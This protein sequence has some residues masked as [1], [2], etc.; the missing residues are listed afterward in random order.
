[1]LRL[2]PALA[3][4]LGLAACDDAPDPLNI[5][6]K[7]FAESQILAEMMAALAEDAGIP[8]TRRLN[9]G[10]TE[11]LLEA[12]KRG[13]IDLYPEYNG[14]G[15]V[16]LGQ[17]A[18][19]D[20]DAA[21]EEVAALYEPLG[22]IWGER[23]GFDNTYGL[24]MRAGRA[25]ELGVDRIS[26]LAGQAGDLTIGVDENFRARP[27]DGL[28]PM[29]ARYG[30]DFGT[31][32]TVTPDERP[33]LYNSVLGGSADVIEV[34][35]TDGQIADL[36]LVLLEDDLD[37][38]PVYQ[39]APLVRS[40]AL[41]RH[42]GLRDVL[43]TLAGRLDPATMQRLN[44]Q[45]DLDSL[46]PR[47]VARAAL[48]EMGLI[49]GD[50]DLDVSE[51][52]VVA[53]SPLVATD[54]MTGR[55]LR[56]VREAYTGRR[57]VLEEAPDALDA[58]GGGAAPLAIASAVEFVDVTGGS[59]PVQRPYEAVGVVGQS[60]VHVVATGDARSLADVGMLATGPEGSASHRA[61]SVLATGFDG[62]TVA[63][64]D[65]G[66]L[67][68]GEADAVLV[69]APVGAP[70]VAALLEDGRLIPVTGWNAGSNL[71]RYP[72]LREARI[73]AGTYDGQR[74]AVD[75]LSSQLVLAGPVIADTDAVG[76]Q[77]PAA[78]QPTEV[79]ALSEKTVTAIDAAL[80]SPTGIDP[81][82]PRAAALTPTLPEPAAAVSPSP[83]TASL[84]VGVF[85]LFAWLVWLYA[86]P[87]R[88]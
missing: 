3:L 88:R 4:I 53:I 46:A 25:A 81:A 33:R 22:L 12:L 52:V 59:D 79:A 37:F 49:D 9:L 84:T 41:V 61:A 23:L 6:S 78:S 8:V 86:R 58:V 11:T 34:F 45:V 56:A 14:T 20:G 77:G 38:F 54:A 5:G 74:D 17:P 50:A 80:A 26:D 55:A 87:E 21:S 73:P 66:D 67:A 16:M 10:S 65:A 62:M 2:I 83:A 82:I 43:G 47:D 35:T 7:D 69:L 39:A 60:F 28:Q 71:V 72:Q 40:D 44:G 32:D 1:M 76:P 31:V 70:A 48:I 24:A 18:M 57:V 42:P 30:I 63:P 75:T 51:P 13:D 27:L 85:V 19:S 29:S 68:G 36:D 15:L 64:R